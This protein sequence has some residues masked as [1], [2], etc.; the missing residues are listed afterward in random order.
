MSVIY[1]R[2]LRP[3]DRIVVIDP[4]NAFTEDGIRGMREYLEGKGFEVAFSKD[5][6]FRRGTPR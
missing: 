3:G 6:A 2:P 1:P 4:A 5:M